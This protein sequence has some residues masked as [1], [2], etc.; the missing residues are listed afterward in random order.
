MAASDWPKRSSN[1]WRP[2]PVTSTVDQL[3][4]ILQEEENALKGGK[5][6]GLEDLAFRK[7]R[8]LENLDL[9][10]PG[11]ERVARLASRNAVLIKAT[12][13]GVASARERLE[14]HRNADFPL[15]TYSADGRRQSAA[16]ARP[17]MDLS[18]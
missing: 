4:D 17:T 3:F 9:D 7:E 13:S 5:L 15:H 2:V 11:M 14:S 18:R 1:P 10:A 8:A 12:M 16:I 6:Q